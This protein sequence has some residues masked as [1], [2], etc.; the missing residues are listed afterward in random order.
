MIATPSKIGIW[1]AFLI[2]NSSMQFVWANYLISSLDNLVWFLKRS[3]DWSDTFAIC[4]LIFDIIFFVFSSIQKYN[5]NW[6]PFHQIANH[7]SMNRS[8]EFAASGTLGPNDNSTECIS[9]REMSNGNLSLKSPFCKCQ[10]CQYTSFDIHM[11]FCIP[12]CI[13]I[14]R[15]LCRIVTTYISECC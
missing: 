7:W 10:H 6:I 1:V 5:H 9:F 13:N 3:S 11:M 2:Y 8:P 14:H 4:I 12:A 15:N